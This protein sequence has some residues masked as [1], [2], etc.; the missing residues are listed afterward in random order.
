MGAPSEDQAV[1]QALIREMNEAVAC[2]DKEIATAN[3]RMAET[4]QDLAALNAN[5]LRR[6][7]VRVVRLFKRT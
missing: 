4:R 5:P 2:L 6:W 7:V 3:Q 1:E